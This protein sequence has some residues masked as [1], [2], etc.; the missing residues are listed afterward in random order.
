SWWRGR[1][2]SRLTYRYRMIMTC[3][4]N[5]PNIWGEK[6]TEETTKP[7]SEGGKKNF[8]RRSPTKEAR[9][10]ELANLPPEY[11]EGRLS[12]RF[13]ERHADV[14][15]YVEEWGMWV[16]WDGK[17]WVKS[18]TY[19]FDFA[20]RIAREASGELKANGNFKAATI[21]YSNRVV[22]AI[23]SLARKN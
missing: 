8:R 11:S 21:V 12:E 14:L 19:A 7:E 17:K 6:M 22:A 3:T 13:T 18:K 16:H 23:E 2:C 1:Y 5:F 9:D 15:R 10:E 4:K 20:R